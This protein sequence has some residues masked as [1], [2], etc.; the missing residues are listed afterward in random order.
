M[1]AVLTPRSV[2]PPAWPEGVDPN[3]PPAVLPRMTREE[4]L[5]F[6]DACKSDA[7]KY[8]WIDGKVRAMTGGTMNH[9]RVITNLV[10]TVDDALRAARRPDRPRYRACG[11]ELRTRVPDGP[12]YYP[13]SLVHPVPADIEE[14]PDRPQRTLLNPKLVA[15]VL[16]PSSRRTDFLEKPA[17]YLLIPT[18]EYYLIVQP[19]VREVIRLTRAGDGWDERTFRTA[20]VDLPRLGIALPL[21]RIYEDASPGPRLR[22]PRLNA[23]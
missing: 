3:H 13:D 22:D 12:Y 23:A 19:N 2:A 1:N 11:S 5:A 9:A 4:Y 21:D 8:E 14:P 15:E 18:V 16:S 20:D 10:V 7:W 17:E 6:D